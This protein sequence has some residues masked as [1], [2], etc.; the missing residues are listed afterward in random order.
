LPESA[1]RAVTIGALECQ[2][3]HR[4]VSFTEFLAEWLVTNELCLSGDRRSEEVCKEC[5][6]DRVLTH[7]GF[8]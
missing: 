2:R 6:T 8:V 7:A 3:C 1:R 5:L 4:T